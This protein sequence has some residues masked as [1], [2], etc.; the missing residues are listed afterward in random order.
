VRLGVLSLPYYVEKTHLYAP[1]AEISPFAQRRQLVEF[2]LSDADRLDAIVISAERGSAWT[3]LHPELAVAVPNPP[4][5]TV[6]LGYPVARRDP[7]LRA[8]L[9]SWIELKRRDGSF[10][11]LYAYWILGENA[12]PRAPRWS[13]LRDVLGWR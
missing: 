8:F 5:L 2:F 11:E 12:Q 10:D 6:P 3:L 13:V 1:D 7:E 9:D 4:V